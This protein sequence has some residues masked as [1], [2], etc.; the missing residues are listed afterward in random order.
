MLLPADFVEDLQRVQKSAQRISSILDLDQLIDSVVN[1]VAHSFGCV[2]ASVY[3]HDEE[4]G[5]MVMTGVCGCTVHCKGHR[6]K[7]GCEGMVGYVAA[8]G[9]MRYAPDV[10]KDPY[11]IGCEALDTVGSSDS[12]ARG[13]E[14]RGRIYGFASRSWTRFLVSN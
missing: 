11:Y 3:L 8:N 7:I 1:E 13:R 5:E 4:R 14:T 10:R 12:A 2:E 6:L 9:Q